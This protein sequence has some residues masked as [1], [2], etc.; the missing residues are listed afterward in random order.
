MYATAHQHRVSNANQHELAARGLVEGWLKR[1]AGYR[2]CNND[3]QQHANLLP[4]AEG[5]VAVLDHVHDLPLHRHKKQ[6]EPAAAGAR[7]K[8]SG[9]WTKA[10]PINH[11]GG[12][13][14]AQAVCRLMLINPFCSSCWR[15]CQEE[16]ERR[17][18]E[19]PQPHQYS[20]RMGQKTGT[21]NMGIKVAVKPSNTAFKLLH[22]RQQT[23]QQAARPRVCWY[24]SAAPFETRGLQIESRC[25]AVHRGG[26]CA[27]GN[28]QHCAPELELWQAAHKGSELFV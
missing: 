2:G 6:N 3:K 21:S 17:R 8:P 14:E 12:E 1:T 13:H 10:L 26:C 11:W 19:R 15:Q 20:T 4:K 9:R 5:H 24:P 18:E 23:Q 7:R 16:R 27:A 22:L 28:P 25:F